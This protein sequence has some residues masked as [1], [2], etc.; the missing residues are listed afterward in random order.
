[1]SSFRRRQ[2]LVH[3]FIHLSIYPTPVRALGPPLS[4]P[5]CYPENQKLRLMHTPE[6]QATFMVLRANGWSLGKISDKMKI[7]KSTLFH[8]DCQCRNEIHKI[9]C[10]Q[11]EKLQERYAPSYEEELQHLAAYLTRIEQALQKQRFERMRPEF[12]LRTALNLRARFNKLRTDVPVTPLNHT[13]APIPVGGCLSRAERPVLAPNYEPVD[14]AAWLSSGPAVRSET[15]PA[16]AQEP[17]L[18]PLPRGEGRGEGEGRAQPTSRVHLDRNEELC[19]T[20]ASAEPINRHL[21][22]GSP[23]DK[24]HHQN[25]T[26]SHENKNSPELDASSSEPSTNNHGTIVPFSMV[27]V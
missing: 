15:S 3:P 10:L 17:A 11:V 1:M 22:N 6:E 5:P 14:H 13:L 2:R 26:F 4:H 19:L 12:L 8:W 24:S 7:P 18:L 27:P 25:G 9:K 23:E 16:P 21:P 20:A